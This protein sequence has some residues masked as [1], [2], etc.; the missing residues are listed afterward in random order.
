M[1]INLIRQNGRQ[2][3]FV[4]FLNVLCQCNGKAVRTNQWRVCNMLV[5]PF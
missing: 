3:R 5:K 4:K 1:F 2:G